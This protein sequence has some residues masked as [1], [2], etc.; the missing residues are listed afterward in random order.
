MASD[1][2]ASQ[3]RWNNLRTGLLFVAGIALVGVLALIIGRNSSTL[4][5]KVKYKLFVSDI[6]GLEENNLVSVAGKKVG[7]V[8][9]L[10]FKTRNDTIGV[11]IDME[12]S[13][14]FAY[15]ITDSVVATIKGQGILGDKFVAITNTSPKGKKLPEGAYLPVIVEE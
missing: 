2:P 8:T 10:S 11:E 14:E 5:S 6:G 9:L 3:L 13:D 7:N 12:V 4:T 15:L 1:N